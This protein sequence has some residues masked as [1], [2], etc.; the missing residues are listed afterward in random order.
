LQEGRAF[1]R[2]TRSNSQPRKKPLSPGLFFT[3]WHFF[4]SFALSVL[5]RRGQAP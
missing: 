3:G 5:P 4:G 2:W 1:E